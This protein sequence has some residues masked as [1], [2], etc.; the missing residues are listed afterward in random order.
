MDCIHED[1]LHTSDFTNQYLRST[2]TQHH[3][4]VERGVMG[5]AVEVVKTMR[6]PWAKRI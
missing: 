4:R 3:D 6:M 1:S 2:A 5:Q